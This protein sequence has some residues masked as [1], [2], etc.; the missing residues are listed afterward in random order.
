[1]PGRAARSRSRR[2][3]PKRIGWLLALWAAGVVALGL[4]AGALRLVM[5]SAGLT[6]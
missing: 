1:M 2:D 6:G 4:V 3:W 5:R